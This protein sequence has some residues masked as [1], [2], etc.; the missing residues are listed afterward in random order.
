[1]E[2]RG[3]Y[4]Y[5]FNP[6][7]DLT[8]G[9]GATFVPRMAVRDL[10]DDLAMLPAL[11]AAAGDLVVVPERPAPAFLQALQ[12]AGLPVPELV[13]WEPLSRPPPAE[14]ATRRL[15]DLQPWGWS[16]DSVTAM[17]PLAGQLPESVAHPSM[18][19]HDVGR[20]LYAK[21]WSAAWLAD[22][23]AD[24]RAREGDWI[25]GP[26]VVGSS[27]ASETEAKRLLTA[28]FGGSWQRAVVKADYGAAGGQQMIVGAADLEE[29]Q[30]RWLRRVL[31]EA[32]RVVIEPWLDRKLDLS[33]QFEVDDDGSLRLLGV[34][35]FLADGRG[36]FQGVFVHNMFG[37]SQPDVTH[38]LDD[39]GRDSRR[40]WRLFDHIGACLHKCLPAGFRGAL[41]ID[42]FVYH[43]TTDGALRLKPIVEVNPRFTMGRVALGLA[44]YILASRTA[45]WRVLRVKDIIDGGNTNVA[46][47]ATRLR[48]ELPLE[49]TGDGKQISRG[50][51]FTNEP[52]RARSFV[53]LVVVGDGPQVITA[54][55]PGM[56]G[57]S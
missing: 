11:L 35:R 32:G 22:I 51:V 21:T 45:I 25:C 16:P 19:W 4:L 2:E 57:R 55:V 46:E 17:T 52:E 43:D 1:M 13:V 48:R 53:S 36:R 40:L 7:C 28:G 34:T 24:L 39:D 6:A 26:E 56:E 29:Y 3:P 9:R 38:L 5:W 49:M 12:M 15:A 27:C 10:A 14:L 23:V 30:Q 18:R 37:G 41:G 54:A 20:E 44:P 42:A 50:V 47:W 31:R 8:A 33:A